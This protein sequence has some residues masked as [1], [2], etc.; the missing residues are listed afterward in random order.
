MALFDF[1]FYRP[2]RQQYDAPKDHGLE[3]EP[4][5]IMTRDDVRLS[6]WWF[7]ADGE[8]AGTVIHCHGNAGNIT[9][10]FVQVAWLP[11][12]GYN[13]L[14]FDYRGFGESE[15]TVTRAGTMLDAHAAIDYV[16]AREDVDPARVLLFGQSLG[17]TVA[18]VAASERDDLAGVAVDG[19]FSGYQEEVEWILKQH[20]LTR[21]VA[22]LIARVGISRAHD[23]IDRVHLVAPT[24][25][26]LMHG[27]E[28]R[29][30]PW[31]MS[32]DLY[33]RAGEPKG[34]WLIPGVG[35]YEALNEMAEIGRPKLL[36]FFESCVEAA[37]IKGAGARSRGL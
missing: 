22:K 35:H 19:P 11:A 13:V 30:C 6:G 23:A 24:P 34:L 21:S 20:W 9:G 5:E 12:A 3:H 8:A 1:Q 32:Q 4:I 33:D 31:E 16:L 2:S 36:Q 26:F 10:H 18:I 14:C 17:G 27:K 29:I 28:D 7:P 37:K 15:G 25:L